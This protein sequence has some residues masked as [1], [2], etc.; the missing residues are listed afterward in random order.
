M[1]VAMKKRGGG[2]VDVKRTVRVAVRILPAVSD[3]HL[4]ALPQG[5]EEL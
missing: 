4:W 2:G 1:L 3:R 5:G